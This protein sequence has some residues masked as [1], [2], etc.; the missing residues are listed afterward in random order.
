MEKNPVFELSEDSPPMD[1]GG[2]TY[3]P[4]KES[5]Q[6]PKK[7]MSG[8]VLALAVVAVAVLLVIVAVV[9]IFAFRP[10]STTSYSNIETESLQQ[11]LNSLRQLVSQLE[12]RVNNTHTSSKDDSFKALQLQV[13]T[14]TQIEEMRYQLQKQNES[15]V[16]LQSGL[17]NS[18]QMLVENVT[19]IFGK[20]SEQVAADIQQLNHSNSIMRSELDT[21]KMNQLLQH[22]ESI[23][24]L[25]TEVQISKQNITNIG[26]NL[27][28]VKL[29]LETFKI[30]QLQSLNNSVI[31]LQSRL[32]DT[33]QILQE[34]PANISLQS[35]ALKKLSR[36]VNQAS[37][38]IQ[39]VN[40]S[41]VAMNNDLTTVI[42]N[43]NT[44]LTF[45]QETSQGNTSNNSSYILIMTVL[46]LQLH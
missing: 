38:D 30:N 35:S 17:Q 25:Q 13:S 32:H 22:N 26:S 4:H 10:T 20:L 40:D 28:R 6:V 34:I 15:I 2:R 44:S 23:E 31:E 14:A 43:L 8:R 19:S 12:Q 46:I 45:L 29:T 33:Q 9:A 41:S 36:Q 39:R 5:H 24:G 42:D 18:K 37:E 7:K 3:S 16:D 1:R 27:A 11:Q 21:V